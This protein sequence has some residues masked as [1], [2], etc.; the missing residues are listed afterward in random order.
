MA[1]KDDAKSVSDD[2]NSSN[3]TKES[4]INESATLELDV[5]MLTKEQYKEEKRRKQEELIKKAN[6][7][8]YGEESFQD[9]LESEKGFEKDVLN[10]S[11][12]SERIE[13]YLEIVDDFFVDRDSEPLSDKEKRII[14]DVIQ[15]F[16]SQNRFS[17]WIDEWL[18]K[19]PGRTKWRKWYKLARMIKK[20]VIPRAKD[21]YKYYYEKFMEYQEQ[22]V[23][24]QEQLARGEESG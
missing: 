23:A 14:F 19:T 20:V 11:E 15:S 5:T 3:S 1:T 6:E 9:D 12:F 4:N 13:E 24:Y 7:K 17:I 16:K 8:K 10:E 21:I 22:V 18:E 2:F